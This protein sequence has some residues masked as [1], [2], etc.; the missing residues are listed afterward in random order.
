MPLNLD[1]G[2]QSHHDLALVEVFV[3][4]RRSFARCRCKCGK[5]VKIALSKWRLVP[6]ERCIRCSVRKHRIVGAGLHKLRLE[7]GR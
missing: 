5:L 7:E 6:P 4:G 2:R 1:P 3:A